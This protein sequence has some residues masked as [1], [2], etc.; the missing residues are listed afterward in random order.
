[1]SSDEVAVE[2]PGFASTTEE[3]AAGVPVV[4]EESS[5]DD[6]PLARSRPAANGKR[7]NAESSDEDDKPLVSLDFCSSIPVIGVRENINFMS[8]ARS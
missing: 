6:A 3:L 5:D 1:M 7:V 2:A 8:T 4:N